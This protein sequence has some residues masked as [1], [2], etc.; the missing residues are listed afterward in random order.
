[1]EIL[2]KVTDKPK[3][4]NFDSSYD[5]QI[6]ATCLRS[7]ASRLKMKHL[8]VKKVKSNVL[9][10]CGE[11]EKIPFTLPVRYKITAAQMERAQELGVFNE[12][13]G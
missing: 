12:A 7:L 1:M 6:A 9:V 8:N 11:L 13:A 10:W 2:A 4:V 3:E 5:A